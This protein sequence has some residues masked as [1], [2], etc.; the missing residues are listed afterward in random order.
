MSVLR[1]Q[2]CVVR[3]VLIEKAITRANAMRDTLRQL[4]G[5]VNELIVSKMNLIT[6]APGELGIKAH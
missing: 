3:C 6:Q 5:D 2:Q 1:L 4:Q